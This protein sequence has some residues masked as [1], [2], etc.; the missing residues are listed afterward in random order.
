MRVQLRV[1]RPGVP[2]VERRRD[3][4]GDVLLHH[5]GL[6]RP[7]GEHMLLRVGDH[8]VQCGLVRRIDQ[9]LSR[10]IRHRP[11]HAHGLRGAERQ[12]KPGHRKRRLA[13]HTARVDVCR[14]APSRGPAQRLPGD[15]V[16][17]IPSI[18][19]RCSSLTV[20]PAATPLPPFRP[21]S[22]RPR[23]R[24]GGVPDSAS[25]PTPHAPTHQPG[26]PRT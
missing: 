8:M 10:L 18:R 14:P 15:R 9:P 3:H 13:R 5:P 12:V 20:D 24:P 4:P 1:P 6:A 19:N 22:P 23:K 7:G 11:R 26:R 21:A 2:M 16:C 25:T 17:N